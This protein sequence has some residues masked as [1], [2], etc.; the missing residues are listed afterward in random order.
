MKRLSRLLQVM[1]ITLC[2]VASP[3]PIAAVSSVPTVNVPHFDGDIQFSET[4]IFWFGQVTSQ[5]NYVDVRMGYNDGEL[6]VRMAAVDRWLWYQ[7]QPSRDTLA[8][9]DAATL[10]LSLDGNA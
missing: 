8:D 5:D 1:G 2:L 9:W 3:S 4:A 7:T 10:Y 6:Y